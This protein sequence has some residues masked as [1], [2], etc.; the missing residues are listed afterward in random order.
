MLQDVINKVNVIKSKTFKLQKLLCNGKYPGNPV[1]H[2]DSVII[3]LKGTYKNCQN[4]EW[5]LWSRQVFLICCPLLWWQGAVRSMLLCDLK[6]AFWQAA[7]I[8]TSFYATLCVIGNYGNYISQIPL[9]P[10][11]WVWFNFCQCIHVRFRRWEK[12]VALLFLWPHRAKCRPWS[13]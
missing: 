13:T 11:L 12:K 8:P 9:P 2:R 7:F 10:R 6:T 5:I 4:S 3:L 1:N